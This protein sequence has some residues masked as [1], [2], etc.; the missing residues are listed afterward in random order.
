MTP[1]ARAG[2]A[3][4]LLAAGVAQ[5]QEVPGLARYMP[6]YPGMYFHGSYVQDDRDAVFDQQGVERDSASPSTGGQTAFPEKTVVGSFL[7]HFP[8]FESQ[9]LPFVSSRTHLAR[10]TFSYTDTQTE[11]ALA[12]FAANSADDASTEADK[13]ENDGSG[14]GDL[15]LEFGSYLYGS[16]ARQ[17][18][19]RQRAPLAIVAIAGANL[20][21]G[22]YN[23]DAPINAGSNTAW[24]QGRV[25]AH[26]QPWAGA[27]VDAGAAYRVYYQNYDANFGRTAPTEQGDDKFADVSLAH[28]VFR[29]LYVGVSGTKRKGARNMYENPRFAPNPPP[30][31]PTTS[32]AP[33]PGTYFDDG[34]ALETVGVSV[35]YFVTQRWLAALHYTQPQSGKSGEFDLPYNEHSPAGCKNGAVNCTTTPDSVVHVDGLGPARSYSSDRLMLTLT[36]NFGLGDAFTCT[37][38]RQ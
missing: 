10:V 4:V 17:W 14:N 20:P 13:L 36:Y 23:R 24:L 35:H 38:C 8:M 33:A 15:L 31:G 29:D 21:F 5:A 12:V 32:M 7:W 34:T 19:E 26:W 16:S 22:A 2:A 30:P 6:L 18:R 27:F 25:G 9:D 3:L 37:G 28:R 1:H 11:G